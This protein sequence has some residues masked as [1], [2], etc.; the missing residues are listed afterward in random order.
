M[1][2]RIA[3]T[4]TPE[5]L[6][7]LLGVTEGSSRLGGLEPSYNVPPS[8]ELPALVSSEAGTAWECFVWG[9][10]PSW[11]GRPVINARSETV[12]EK[13]FFRR[14][15]RERR[16]VVPVTAYYEWKA[17]GEPWCIRPAGPKPLL[18][19]GLYARGAC[20]VLTR[21]AREDL[22]EIH[23][24]MPVAMPHDL[25]EPWLEDER[26]AP[27]VFEATLSLRLRAYR[28][29]R[30]VGSPRFNTPACLEPA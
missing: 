19:A 1:C 2:G 13:P 26:A 22:A 25:V 14:S 3:Q 24:R 21:A 10:A 27:H 11:K 5:E 28:V 4:H 9:M 6:T 17:R 18:L 7:E 30:S 12:A 8:L 16:C 20:V 29:A 15:F 23:H